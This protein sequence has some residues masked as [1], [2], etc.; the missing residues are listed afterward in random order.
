M[1]RPIRLVTVLDVVRT[2]CRFDA[3]PSCVNSAE[4]KYLVL[5]R[6]A[7]IQAIQWNQMPDNLY[8]STGVGSVQTVLSCFVRSLLEE[9]GNGRLFDAHFIF[10]FAAFRTACKDS[11]LRKM[12]DHV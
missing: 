9:A 3:Q 4:G 7:R 10:I 11:M 12:K 1:W 5:G 6:C 8:L 2:L